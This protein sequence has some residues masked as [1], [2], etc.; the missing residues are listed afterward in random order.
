MR[1]AVRP[2]GQ[3]RDKREFEK[4][5]AGRQRH[6]AK[7]AARCTINNLRLCDP[8]SLPQEVVENAEAETF[9]TPSYAITPLSGFSVV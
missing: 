6:A 4:W 9:Q 2:D 5:V 1:C 8:P 7:N 3:S